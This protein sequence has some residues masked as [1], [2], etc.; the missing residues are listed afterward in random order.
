MRLP[1]GKP[2]QKGVTCAPGTTPANL[3][4]ALPQNPGSAGGGHHHPHLQEP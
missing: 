1:G 3:P 4:K 2:G